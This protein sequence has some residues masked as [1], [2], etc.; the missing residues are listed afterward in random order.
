M[1]EAEETCR[2]FVQIWA[3]AVMRQVERV[4]EVRRNARSLGR[5][6]E[7]LEDYSPDVLDLAR[8]FRA[9]WAEEQAL[10]LGGSPG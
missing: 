9:Q 3:E 5:A 2:S 8:S 7:R 10:V 1:I 6:Y 4:R